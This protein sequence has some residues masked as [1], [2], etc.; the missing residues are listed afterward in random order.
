MSKPFFPFFAVLFETLP[1][2]RILFL[3]TTAKIFRQVNVI[4]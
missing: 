1:G 3:E 4:F 2:V